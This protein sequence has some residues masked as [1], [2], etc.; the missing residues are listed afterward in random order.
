MSPHQS[1][2]V[3]PTVIPDVATQPHPT[4]GILFDDNTPEAGDTKLQDL[5]PEINELAQKVGG[6]KKLSEIIATL[7]KMGK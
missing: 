4:P 7:A 3:D 5:L 1:Y 6:Y 2:G